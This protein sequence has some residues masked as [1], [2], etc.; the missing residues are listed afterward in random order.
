MALTALAGPLSNIIL[1]FI[2]LFLYKCVYAAAMSNPALLDTGFKYN[3][4][5]LILE[6]FNL[7]CIL[8]LYLG[9]FNLIPVPPLD[10]SR[11]LFVVLPDNIYFGVMQYERYIQIALFALLYLGVLS[12]PLSAACTYILNGMDALLSLLPIF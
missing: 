10:G 5:M 7:F 4:V 12:Q 9:V 11:I 3:L 6:F 2:G 1:S 8:N